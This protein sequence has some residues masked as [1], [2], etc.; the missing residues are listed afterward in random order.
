MRQQ[1][2]A[3]QQ[4]RGLQQ[5]EHAKKKRMMATMGP[6]PPTATGKIRANQRCRA[7]HAPRYPNGCAA[8]RSDGRPR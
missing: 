3:E 7:Q 8:H 4:Q 2:V 6:T 5:L 1:Q